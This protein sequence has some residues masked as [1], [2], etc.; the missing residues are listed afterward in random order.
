MWVTNE[1]EDDLLI[2]FFFTVCPEGCD[3]EY[4][5]HQATDILQGSR[6]P[7]SH[8]EYQPPETFCFND[9]LSPDNA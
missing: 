7:N 9:P 4:P 1:L 6:G 2:Y 3:E 5:I 8:E